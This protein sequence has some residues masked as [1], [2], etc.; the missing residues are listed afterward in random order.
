[1][2]EIREDIRDAIEPASMTDERIVEVLSDQYDPSA[3]RLALVT[4]LDD[5]QLEE[6]P[7]F[8]DTYR[9]PGE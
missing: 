4:M 5:D 6:H 8:E 3:V 2:S 7:H 9:L 1:M